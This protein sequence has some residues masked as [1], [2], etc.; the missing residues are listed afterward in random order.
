ME[1]FEKLHLSAVVVGINVR[2]IDIESAANFLKAQNH[3]KFLWKTYGTHDLLFVMICDKANVGES[4]YELKKELEESG[5]HPK[6]LDASTSIT[7][8]KIDLSPF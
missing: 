6:K 3:V 2:T 4:L 5:I 7:W 1:K 8:D